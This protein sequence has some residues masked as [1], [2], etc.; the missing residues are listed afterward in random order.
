MSEAAKA[1]SIYV[2]NTVEDRIPT[3][4]PLAH[5][6]TA[7]VAAMQPLRKTF[8][9]QPHSMMKSPSAWAPDSSSS[10]SF[11]HAYD[12]YVSSHRVV[13]P[14]TVM[15]AERMLLAE[16][17]E[18]AA[19][20]R[21]GY[22][23]PR[24]VALHLL[25]PQCSVRGAGCVDAIDAM[26]AFSDTRDANDAPAAMHARFSIFAGSAASFLE[27]IVRAEAMG[28]RECVGCTMVMRWS[29]ETCGSKRIRTE[30]ARLPAGDIGVETMQTTM[31][32]IATRFGVDLPPALFRKPSPCRE[33]FKRVVT[34][35]GNAF[36]NMVNTAV[37]FDVD[38]LQRARQC[39]LLERLHDV[40]VRVSKRE[41]GEKGCVD[42]A[43]VHGLLLCRDG[44]VKQAMHFV[45]KFKTGLPP[46]SGFTD[47]ATR[48][49][50][51]WMCLHTLTVSAE[52]VDVSNQV[53]LYAHSGVPGE[54]T[55]SYGVWL[56][57]LCVSI[58][59][60]HAVQAGCHIVPCTPRSMVPAEAGLGAFVE[61]GF[62]AAIELY[63]QT[64]YETS[65]TPREAL[66]L[67]PCAR[68]PEESFFLA[69]LKV[70]LSSPK[71]LVGEAIAHLVGEG[72]PRPLVQMLT[73]VAGK[74]GLSAPLCKVFEVCD[75]AL[76]KGDN[77]DVA[78]RK[79]ISRLK[80]IADAA[81]LIGCSKRARAEMP[82]ISK[83]KV[84]ALM[85]VFK[86]KSD[87]AVRCSDKAPRPDS[88]KELALAVY[89]IHNKMRDG[90]QPHL[91][92]VETVCRDVDDV[93][94]AVARGLLTCSVGAAA[95][96]DY[97]L[98][99]HGE[100]VEGVEAYEVQQ[101]GGVCRC[102]AGRIFESDA[103]AVGSLKHLT[104]GSLLTPLVKEKRR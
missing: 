78:A 69:A 10:D 28:E 63:H 93:L 39:Q 36:Y 50:I 22:L 56:W 76:K 91:R 67:P 41:Q 13:H 47:A 2:G 66:P 77:A 61:K 80:R 37:P 30:V 15:Q 12:G 103:P 88:A 89:T 59:P 14:E 45:E 7:M 51:E 71:A 44:A 70:D 68:S 81:L 35:V 5:P 46:A 74:H 48:D 42:D 98:L 40:V 86:L 34:S 100:G 75:E 54:P 92:E 53:S 38:A 62:V 4:Q 32:A 84:S 55:S 3:L 17:E 43:A 25:I 83:N 18:L 73:N 72:A 85:Q 101:D 29:E 90:P 99:V 9:T 58:Q 26:A 96:R 94:E 57:K 31:A 1:Q 79:E 87:K 49:H 16:R 11:Q 95:R 19:E 60:I 6:L 33:A 97:F 23:P 20:P 8:V 27:S 52:R 104:A 64:F 24:K 21:S 102:G 65:S 82:A